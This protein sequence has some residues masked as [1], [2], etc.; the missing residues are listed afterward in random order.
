MNTNSCAVTHF[1]LFVWCQV[2]NTIVCKLPCITNCNVRFCCKIPQRYFLHL[3]HGNILF[4]TTTGNTKWVN[5]R[6]WDEII[7][8]RRTLKGNHISLETWFISNLTIRYSTFNQPSWHYVG[9]GMKIVANAIS[10]HYIYS[11]W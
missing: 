3:P 8:L 2:N 10:K 9:Q 4:L 7:I 1:K 5:S 6:K 11:V